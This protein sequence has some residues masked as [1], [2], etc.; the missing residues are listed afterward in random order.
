MLTRST[1]PGSGKVGGH[2]LGDNNSE[3]PHLAES[4]IGMLQCH[5]VRLKIEK[6]NMYE[7]TLRA[8][9]QIDIEFPFS[10]YLAIEMLI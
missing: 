4:I 1:Y 9:D 8:V 6:K 5:F 3:W 2:W 7:I 10:P